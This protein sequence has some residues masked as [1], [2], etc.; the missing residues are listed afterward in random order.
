MDGTASFDERCASTNQTHANEMA[1]SS[2]AYLKATLRY[3]LNNNRDLGL[4]REAFFQLCRKHR[5]R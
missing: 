3:G 5:V 4:G 1:L 2:L